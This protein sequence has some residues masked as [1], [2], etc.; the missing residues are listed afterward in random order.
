MSS[1]TEKKKC[2]ACGQPNPNNESFIEGEG[3]RPEAANFQV[4]EISLGHS[5][6]VDDISP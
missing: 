2:R 4:A 3:W 5:L 6:P 1:A